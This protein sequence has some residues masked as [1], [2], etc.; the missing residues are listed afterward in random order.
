MEASSVV[1][2][3]DVPQEDMTPKRSPPTKKDKRKSRKQELRIAEDIGGRRQ[4]GSGN[5]AHAKG[6]V[7]KKGEFRIEAKFTRAK[8]FTLKR[9]ELDKINGECSYG[10]KPVFQ[11]DFI[12]S[13]TDKVDDSWVAIPYDDWKELIDA[14]SK[15]RGSGS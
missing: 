2:P 7:R 8:Q 15:N 12:S 14:A 5:Q 13:V 10:E 1:V 11:I 9:E 4:P 3:L 6:D